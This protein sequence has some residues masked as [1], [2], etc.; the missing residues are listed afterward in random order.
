VDERGDDLTIVHGSQRT[1]DRYRSGI[2]EAFCYITTKG[3]RTGRPHQVEI[4][5]AGEPGSRTIYVLAGGRERA[6]FV[7]NAMADPNVTVTIG[8]QEGSATA[9]VVEADT[10]EDAL[11]RRL[12][13]AKYATADDLAGW[14]ATALP[15]AFDLGPWFE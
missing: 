11:A 7:R 12:L 3:R 8:D 1:G 14:G 2:D 5:F 6:D 10:P 9:R 15:V 13:L 4:W